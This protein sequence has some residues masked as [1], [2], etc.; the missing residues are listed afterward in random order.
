MTPA[1]TFAG[2]TVA[3]IGLGASG[4]AAAGSLAAGGATPVCWDDG[5]A[6]RLQ[7]TEAGLTV[8]DL[9]QADFA[10]FSALVLSPGV[11]LTHPEPHWSVAKAKAAGIEIIG[12]IEIFCRERA[13]TAP[14]APFIAVTGTNG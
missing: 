11:P 2:R 9:S 3:V 10:R 7:A 5:E 13:A 4:L 12:D 8:E 1:T 6:A 14:D